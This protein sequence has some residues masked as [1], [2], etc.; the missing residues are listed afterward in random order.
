[1]PSP[2]ILSEKAAMTN[3]RFTV[4]SQHL[5]FTQVIL[6]DQT[7]IRNELVQQREWLL[8]PSE[9]LELQGNLFV[10][11]NVITGD[12]QVLVKLAPL[13]HARPVTSP[14]DITV[15]P[16]KDSGF[17]FIL[18]GDPTGGGNSSTEF[19]VLNYSGGRFGRVRAL[20]SFHL[21]RWCRYLRVHNWLRIFHLQF[22]GSKVQ[23]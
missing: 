2:E 3:K 11:E 5:R 14:V 20:Q 19:A 6:Q 17:D 21:I 10:L 23:L 12:G 8:H 13:P 15:I 22:V 4:R 7:D 18:H 16:R 9:K 1:M